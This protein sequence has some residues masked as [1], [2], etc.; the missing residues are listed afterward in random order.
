MYIFLITLFFHHRFLNSTT[1]IAKLTL[2]EDTMSFKRLLHRMWFALYPRSR[3]TKGSCAFEHVFLGE[4]KNG[5]VNGFHNWL[6]FLLEEQ[7]GMFVCFQTYALSF[8]RS[9]NVLC[10]SK[11][12]EPAQK[13]IYILCQSQTFFARQKDDLHSAK[14]VFVP[15]QNVLKRH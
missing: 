9:L 7:K 5:K 8:Y 2:G 14:L 6:F 3:R 1:N 11:F 12:F 15:A 4:V 10:W 13:F